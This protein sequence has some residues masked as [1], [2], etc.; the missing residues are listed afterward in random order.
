MLD[1]LIEQ[2]LAK[3]EDKVMDRQKTIVFVI[4]DCLINLKSS[5]FQYKHPKKRTQKFKVMVSNL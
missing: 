4:I 2:Y 1:V 3:A 5:G